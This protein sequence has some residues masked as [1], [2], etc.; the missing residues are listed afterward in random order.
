MGTRTRPVG[1]HHLL[2]CLRHLRIEC[3]KLPVKKRIRSR[4]WVILPLSLLVILYFQFDPSRH[5]FPK[6]I[7]KELTGLD[8]FGCGIQRA[9]HC[10]LV[11]DILGAWMHNQLACVFVPLTVIALGFEMKGKPLIFLYTKWSYAIIL[12]IFFSFFIWRNIH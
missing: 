9:I 12:I 8:C 2:S 5:L 7:F 1:D 10:I 4:A 6:C 3:G 11:G